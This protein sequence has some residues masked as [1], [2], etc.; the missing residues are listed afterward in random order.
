MDASTA[1][2]VIWITGLS[3]SGKTTVSRLLKAELERGGERTLLLDG[4]ALRTLMPQGGRFDRQ[5]RLE[6]ALA[7]GKL[8]KLVAEQGVSVICA[9]ISMR[10]EVYAWNRANLPGYV[11]VYLDVEAGLRAARDPKRLYQRH[12]TGDLKEM[13]GRDQD[14]DYPSAPHIHLKPCEGDTPEMTCAEILKGLVALRRP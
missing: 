13:A 9:T 7:Y 6:L 3:G 10:R 11:E 5:S 4:D 2:R 12:S 8:C 14:V 1:G